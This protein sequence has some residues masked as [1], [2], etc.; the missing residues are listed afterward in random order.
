M[1]KLICIVCSL[2]M[3]AWKYLDDVKKKKSVLYTTD[4]QKEML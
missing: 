2:F 4:S 3:Q 1:N